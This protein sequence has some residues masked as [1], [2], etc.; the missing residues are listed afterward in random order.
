MRLLL[1]PFILAT[2]LWH[3]AAPAVPDPGLRYVVL[4]ILPQIALS[5]G[6]GLLLSLM[7]T[8]SGGIGACLTALFCCVCLPV[9]FFGWDSGSKDDLLPEFEWGSK[10]P[11]E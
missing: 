3:W 9:V 4:F 8:T 1:L 6:G 10:P 2:G 5:Q 7:G 11:G